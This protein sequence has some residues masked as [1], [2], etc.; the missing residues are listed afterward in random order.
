MLSRRIIC[1]FFVNFFRQNLN[2]LQQKYLLL[3]LGVVSGFVEKPE[4]CK[5]SSAKDFCNEKGLVNL[6][7]I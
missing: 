4:D 6:C 3:Q 7:L 2:K 5:Y 1:G